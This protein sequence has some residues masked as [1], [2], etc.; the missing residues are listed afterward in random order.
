MT[1]SQAPL[2]AYERRK[3][4]SFSTKMS[5]FHEHFNTL[6][7]LADGSFNNRGMSLSS[8]LRL[9]DDLTHHLTMHHTIEERYIFPI[10]GT[11]MKQFSDEE[12]GEHIESHKGIHKEVLFKHLDQEVA[13][14]KG[15]NMRKYWKLEELDS[16]PM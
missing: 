6:Y 13:D 9:G 15:E 3:W 16:I 2:S 5:M 7:E 11:R 4:D 12:D 10:L 1:D 8:Y 14:L